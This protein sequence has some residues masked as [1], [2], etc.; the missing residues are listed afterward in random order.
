MQ[1]GIRVFQVSSDGPEL[2]RPIELVH[3]LA[4]DRSTGILKARGSLDIIL[5]RRSSGLESLHHVF[6]SNLFL[7]VILY[8]YRNPVF[9]A[10]AGR[11]R[12]VS[13]GV[14]RWAAFGR[15]SPSHERQ[16]PTCWPRSMC[17]LVSSSLTWP[18]RGMQCHLV[19]ASGLSK[20]RT[21]CR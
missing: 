18:V 3:T 13:F 10:G 5:T 1:L 19:S 8:T 16:K 21:P 14:L 7:N 20:R 11:V 6:T 9:G 12:F 4:P 2:I 15:P 17:R